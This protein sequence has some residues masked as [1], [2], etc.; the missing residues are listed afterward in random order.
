[1]A[2]WLYAAMVTHGSV[3]IAMVTQ[4]KTESLDRTTWESRSQD[5]MMT[6]WHH[7]I[8]VNETHDDSEKCSKTNQII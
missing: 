1:M 5:K 3:I 4:A 6:N 7:D 8:G 2:V